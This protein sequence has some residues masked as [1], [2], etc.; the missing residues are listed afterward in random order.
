MGYVPVDSKP[1]CSTFS[2]LHGSERHSHASTRHVPIEYSLLKVQDSDFPIGSEL[3]AE[4]GVTGVFLSSALA[5]QRRTKDCC[6]RSGRSF[7]CFFPN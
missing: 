5:Y 3:M 7:C 6:Y 4:P 2:F 1:N